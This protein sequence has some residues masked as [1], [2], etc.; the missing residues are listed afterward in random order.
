MILTLFCQFPFVHNYLAHKPCKIWDF[1]I[2]NQVS[3][4]DRRNED[5]RWMIE[6][7]RG[8]PATS[9][10]SAV[11]CGKLFASRM[12]LVR[13]KA[14]SPLPLCRRSPKSFAPFGGHRRARQRLGLRWPSTAFLSA[15][16]VPS[17]FVQSGAPAIKLSFLTTDGSFWAKIVKFKQFTRILTVQ[18]RGKSRFPPGKLHFPTGKTRLPAGKKVLPPGKSLLPPRKTRLPTGKRLLPLG[19]TRL[20]TGKRLLPSGKSRLP[21]GKLRLPTRKTGFPTGKSSLSL[22]DGRALDDGL[23]GAG[24]GA[25]AATEWRK[26]AAHGETGGLVV[27]MIQAPDGAEEMSCEGGF[28]CRSCRSFFRWVHL[29]TARA[30]GYWRALL[31]SFR[32][33]GIIGECFV[34]GGKARPTQLLTAG[35]SACA[36][37]LFLAGSMQFNH[38]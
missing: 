11:R 21:A 9:F 34:A 16:K 8:L 36:G 12:L 7:G 4:G 30:V 35:T 25:M 23:R 1:K 28:F 31:R 26:I 38:G 10:F 14:P 2:S 27:I 17:P 6:D 37:G 24:A 20:P 13:P 29:P 19:K 22:G 33:T 18:M 5:E 32:R 15:N 3:P